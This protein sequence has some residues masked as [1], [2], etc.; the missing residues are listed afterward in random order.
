MPKTSTITIDPKRAQEWATR[1]N[2]LRPLQPST[3]NL[4]ELFRRYFSTVEGLFEKGYGLKPVYE[5]L[6]ADGHKLNGDEAQC[7]STLTRLWAMVKNEKK[8][9]QTESK[10]QKKRKKDCAV[11]INGLAPVVAGDSPAMAEN[12]TGI[13]AGDNP[14]M[15][16]SLVAA[17]A[18]DSPVTTRIVPSAGAGDGLRVINGI[19]SAGVEDS[20][21]QEA[22]PKGKNLEPSREERYQ[23]RRTEND[24]SVRV[25]GLPTSVDAFAVAKR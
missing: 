20:L 10:I 24:P 11:V 7:M 25:H 19:A 6:I 15:A 22:N 18:G 8:H 3:I 4:L 5:A 1:W 9:S 2:N 13:E 17:A 12:L 16:E 14:A 23:Q 21:T